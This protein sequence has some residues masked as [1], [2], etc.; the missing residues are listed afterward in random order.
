[1][2][3]VKEIQFDVKSNSKDGTLVP[4]ELYS[5][6]P[7]IP[8]RVFYVYD[9]PAG[10]IRGKHAHFLTEQILIC[11]NGQVDVTCDD[12]NLKKTYSLDSPNKGLYI[13][14]LVWDECFYVLQNSVLL[15]LSSTSYSPNDYI[16]N[17]RRFL[18]IKANEF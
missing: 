2:K 18:E 6:L 17:Y 7:F 15:V 16:T 3:N 12:G 4:L 11:L 8:R 13:P 14:S 10:S 1:M 9:V 5:S